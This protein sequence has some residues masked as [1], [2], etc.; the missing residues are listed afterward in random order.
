MPTNELTAR[1]CRSELSGGLLLQAQHLFTMPADVVGG[2]IRV[3]LTHRRKADVAHG[4]VAKL[5]GE[6]AEACGTGGAVG[7]RD[8]LRKN[9]RAKSG[10]VRSLASSVGSSH[11]L[12]TDD[13]KLAQRD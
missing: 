2:D 13:V 12:S 11:G 6:D 4:G 7:A 10:D 5:G 3:E 9:L 8:D 1:L